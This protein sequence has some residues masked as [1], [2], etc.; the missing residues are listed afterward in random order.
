[1]MELD[2]RQPDARRYFLY[3]VPER[4]VQDLLLSLLEPG[5]TFMDIGS[6][7]G[8]YALLAS[9][10]VG[11]GGMA[12]AFEPDPDNIDC[13]RRNMSLNPGLD[14]TVEGVAVADIEGEATFHVGADS[15]KGSLLQ[16]SSGDG[17]SF[18]VPTVTLDGYLDAHGIE[19][20]DVLKMDIEGGEVL[21]LEGMADGLEAG[22]YGHIV[23]E[24]HVQS[25]AALGERAARALDLLRSSGYEVL[26]A[27][28]AGGHRPLT[29]EA[30]EAKRVYL[31]CR[32][33]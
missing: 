15:G 22:R 30:L 17:R 9:K 14:V 5:M 20:V 1:M 13:I 23:L 21:A 26:I 33:R 2:L 8:Y 19:R 24:W 6:N 16:H 12:V 25:Q 4:G 29:P 31:Y 32:R 10:V 27:D 28:L 7:W 11:A 3:G 18:T